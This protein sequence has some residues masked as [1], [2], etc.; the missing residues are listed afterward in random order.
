M[1]EVKISELTSATTPLAGTETVPIVQGG[2]TKK[3]SVSNFGGAAVNPTSG[4]IPFNNSGVFANT[5]LSIDSVSGFPSLTADYSVFQVTDPL[6]FNSSILSLDALN[7]YY[8]IGRASANSGGVTASKG[9]AF[10]FFE[11]ILNSQFGTNGNG[12][13]KCSGITGD[14]LIGNGPSRSIGTSDY[15][16]AMHV[17]TSM[18]STGSTT[19]ITRWLKVITEGGTTYR[20]PLYT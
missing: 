4:R 14:M 8:S 5:S 1:A 10:G 16:D 7:G 11:F 19:S 12:L 18:I 20:I 9:A 3:V 17:G 6:D 13:I 15:N 2:V